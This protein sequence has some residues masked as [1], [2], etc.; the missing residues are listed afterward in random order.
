MNASEKDRSTDTDNI[1]DSDKNEGKRIDS[2]DFVKGFAIIFIILAHISVSWFSPEWR[3]LFGVVFSFLDILGPSLFIFLSALSVIFSIRRKEG[4]LPHKVI[5]N[6]ILLRGIVFGIIG[7]IGNIPN[8]L[9]IAKEYPFPLGLWGWNFIMFLGFSQIACY[10]ITKLGKVNRVLIGVMIIFVSTILREL[11]YLGK[12]VNFFIWILDYIINS[13]APA[14][15]VLPWLG[16]CFLSS[17]FGEFLYDT[18]ERGTLKAY[19]YLFK[20]LLTWG[21]IFLL[22]GIICGFY[23]VDDSNTTF[24]VLFPQVLLLDYV[25]AQPFVTW[26]GLPDFFIRSTFSNMWYNLGAALSIIAVFFY[27]IDIKK[28]K[29]VF[30]DL[31]IFYGNISLSL[32]LLH[33]TFIPLFVGQYPIYFFPFVCLSYIGFLGF[34]FYFWNKYANGI[35]TPEW[36]MI[37]M[38]KLGQ[39]PKLT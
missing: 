1:V 6:R 20:L 21:I 2:I 38:G 28:K 35:F 25:N 29:N 15:P 36:I 30:T 27:L 26:L 32:Y 9:L 39:K 37:Q 17:I 16:I 11:L 14:V 13:P 18:M 8:S 4:K 34:L 22:F 7:V 12:D 10:Y 3:F 23:L 31:I 24:N 5:R 33:F 19:N